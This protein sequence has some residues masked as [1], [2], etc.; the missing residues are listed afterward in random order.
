MPNGAYRVFTLQQ[1]SVQST[2]AKFIAN[3]VQKD[4]VEMDDLR[5]DRSP[6]G[7][8]V[9]QHIMGDKDAPIKFS[10]RNFIVKD[11]KTEEDLIEYITLVFNTHT[12]E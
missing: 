7:Q 9:Y 1:K 6:R 8:F 11:G 5:F 10:R 2:L 3:N 12:Q 4:A